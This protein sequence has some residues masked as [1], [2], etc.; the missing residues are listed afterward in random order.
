M[1]SNTEAIP[2]PPDGVYVSSE[3]AFEALR[4]HG[5]TH[6]YGFYK[7][8]SL[9]AGT[10]V[11]TRYRLICDRA[12]NYQSKATIRSTKTRT[13]GC[14]FRATIFKI[15]TEEN[16]DSWR[17]E[18][19]NPTHNHPPSS[20]P[21]VHNVHRK[22]TPADLKTIDSMTRAGSRPKQIFAAIT[23]QNPETLVTP[24]DVRT[25]RQ[26]LRN[27]Q[28]N[29]RTPIETLLDDLKSSP[30]WIYDFKLDSQN[31][32]QNL[33]FAHR[34][35]IEIY[36]AN[37]DVLIVDC[38]YR[39][40]RHNLPLVHIIGSTNMNTYFTIGFCFIRVE[41]Q[42]DYFWALST[43]KNK[44][45]APTPRIFVSDDEDAL[46]NA[47]RNLWPSVIQ[48]LCVWHVNK[49]VLTKAQETWRTA[50]G[51]SKDEKEAI[52]KHRED[53]MMRWREVVYSKTE[54]WFDNR[55]NNLMKHYEKDNIELCEY[56]VNN[57]LHKRFQ[58]ARAWTSKYR[59][60]NTY[61]SSPVEGLHSVLKQY[62]G[63]SRG[64][65]LSVVEKIT[66]MVQ[67]QY[68]NYKQKVSIDESSRKEFHTFKRMPYLPP[69]IHSVVTSAAIE[70]VR[71]QDI[72]RLDKLEKR[73]TLPC[74]GSFKQVYGLPCYHDIQQAIETK[75][76]L[77]MSQFND[78]HWYYKR[79][80]GQP[81]D[82]S[83]RPHRLIL[84][85]PTVQR[86]GATR[87]HDSSTR[88][89]P[90]AFERPVPANNTQHNLFTEALCSVESIVQQAGTPVTS[91]IPMTT[92]TTTI[93]LS[94]TIPATAPLSPVI[95]QPITR[96]S[97][98]ASI[99]LSIS[100][101]SSPRQPEDEQRPPKRAAADKASAAW[102][103][104][105]PRKRQRQ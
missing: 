83:D 42:L 104:L 25:D 34:K 38:T 13:T 27:T 2:V 36:R 77:Q 32:V 73:T 55:W 47:A 19:T 11:K 23:Q 28:L 70:L 46:K 52:T 40:N 48:L 24:R 84:E 14:P 69:G 66:Q 76:P 29:G 12:K 94:T 93:S 99:T 105:S 10:V 92:T 78:E 79:T 89:D 53:F 50:N 20:D 45:Q 65:L 60:Y 86:R 54:R 5:M 22:R 30:D 3:D 102:S 31:R 16:N 91:S 100:V 64:D 90:S 96:L 6:G 37:F 9:P 56:L 101:T 61:T 41:E 63:T 7:E 1:D 97:S 98:P 43:F 33:F 82:M 44:T 74:T 21:R 15:K 4:S 71:K 62:L 95:D 75:R 49:N 81:I 26:M 68:V 87:K 51:K 17:L 88:R 80:S 39:T 103:S 18:T 59:N 58:F 67:K 35:S 57:K 72:L 8:K 85:P